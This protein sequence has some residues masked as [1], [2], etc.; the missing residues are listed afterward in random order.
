M[1]CRLVYPL[2]FLFD[3]PFKAEITVIKSAEKPYHRTVDKR[4]DNR[5]ELYSLKMTKP[6][7]AERKNHRNNTA[8]AIVRLLEAVLPD[9]EIFGYLLDEQIV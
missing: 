7:K 6:E 2:I 5:S 1:R 3:K 9:T 4:T 8:G